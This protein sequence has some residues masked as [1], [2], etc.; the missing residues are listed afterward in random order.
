MRPAGAICLEKAILS[1]GKSLLDPP[2]PGLSSAGPGTVGEVLQ[3]MVVMASE[4]Y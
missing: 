4:G 2:M 1:P 3:T